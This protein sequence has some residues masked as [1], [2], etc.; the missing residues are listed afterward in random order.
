MQSMCIDNVYLAYNST[1]Y[2]FL[3]ELNQ[4][5]PASLL[6]SQTKWPADHYEWIKRIVLSH[7]GIVSKRLNI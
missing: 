1:A 4:N 6:H 7:A 5:K 3:N 2:I